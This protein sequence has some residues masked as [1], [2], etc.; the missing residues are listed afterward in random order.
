MLRFL[1][2]VWILAY[3]GCA[4]REPEV[5][6]VNPSRIEAS[7]ADRERW[8]IE[9]K[10][11]DRAR[12]EAD[13]GWIL[14]ARTIGGQEARQIAYLFFYSAGSNCGA[15]EEPKLSDG[16]WRL[17]FLS[18]FSAASGFPVFVDAKNGEVWQFASTRLDALALIRHE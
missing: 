17:D 12:F 4:V 15:F 1:L 7:L 5:V 2:T 11:R 13:Y 16:I 8:V 6:L 3:I 18:G 14:S 9:Q 10:K